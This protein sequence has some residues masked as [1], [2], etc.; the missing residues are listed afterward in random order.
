MTK[1]VRSLHIFAGW[2]RIVLFPVLISLILSLISYLTMP[3]ALG[4]L[5]SLFLCTCGLITGIIMATVIWKRRGVKA[6]LPKEEEEE[7]PD[8]AETI[9]SDENQPGT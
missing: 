7:V 3:G 1:L 4:I 8:L 5:L 9:N 6:F 2:F